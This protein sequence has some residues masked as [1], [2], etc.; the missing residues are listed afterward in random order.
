MKPTM[1]NGVYNMKKLSTIF[2]SALLI[3]SMALTGCKGSKGE[4]IDSSS[5][6][7]QNVSQ[8]TDVSLLLSA[9]TVNVRVG[10]SYQLNYSV[11]NTNETPIFISQDESVATVDTSGKVIGVSVGETSISVSVG[12]TLKTCIV[13]V[14]A[15]PTYNVKIDNENVMLITG[16]VFQIV[17]GFYH[18]GEKVN[19]ILQFSS[20]NEDVA[21]VSDTGNITAKAEGN[22]VITVYTDYNGT[23]YR[24]YISVLVNPAVYIDC[25]ASI[26]VNYLET[27]TIDYAVRDFNTNEPIADAVVQLSNLSG[28]VLEIS[29]NQITATD[30]QECTLLLKYGTVERK[31]EVNVVLPVQ[32]AEYNAF[33]HPVAL[34]D[35]FAVCSVKNQTDKKINGVS[36]ESVD[37][38]TFKGNCLVVDTAK[39]QESG[40][41]KVSVLVLPSRSSKAE[42]EA[43]QAAGYNYLQI[44]VKFVP[45]SPD[46]VVGATGVEFRWTAETNS[47]GTATAAYFNTQ[48]TFDVWRKINLPIQAVIDQYDL[49]NGGFDKTSNGTQ[50]NTCFMQIFH[51]NDTVNSV[52]VYL[53]PLFFTK[54]A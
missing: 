15:K 25:S 26:D 46:F 53:Q 49:L 20:S 22:C 3:F 8:N 45:S 32:Y 9:S 44:N 1:Q 5:G 38:G 54:T 4:P 35:A 28:S 48:E 29:G 41:S 47:S 52:K 31:V 10:E 23:T 7:N 39:T 17:A 42:I 37:D 13:N 14:S 30:V 19:S 11:K 27:K 21:S 16:N 33:A 6:G 34:K 50:D 40:S 36:F 43:L 12:G 2:L 24:N 51:N 18:E